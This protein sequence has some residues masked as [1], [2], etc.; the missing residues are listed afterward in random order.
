MEKKLSNSDANVIEKG[1]RQN[2]NLS[3]GVYSFD[4]VRRIYLIFERKN[5]ND[6]KKLVLLKFLNDCELRGSVKFQVE[7]KIK[8]KFPKYCFN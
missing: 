3:F 7:Q 4:A 8:R 6:P 1:R 5:V 2:Y